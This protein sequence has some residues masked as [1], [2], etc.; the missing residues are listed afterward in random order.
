MHPTCSVA[1]TSNSSSSIQRLKSEWTATPRMS[2]LYALPRSPECSGPAAGSA[3]LTQSPTTTSPPKSAP[4]G[5]HGLD[6]WPAPYIEYRERLGGGR[7]HRHHNRSHPPGHRWHGLSH[8]QS[9]QASRLTRATRLCTEPHYPSGAMAET[10]IGSGSP[11]TKGFATASRGFSG[12]VVR[13]VSVAVSPINRDTKTRAAFPG[14]LG[15][16]DRECA[17][18]E[19]SKWHNSIGQPRRPWRPLQVHA[20][21]E[22]CDVWR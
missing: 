20:H 8:H 9:H 18:V 22:N 4:S 10:A 3:S 19:R 13:S 7:V 5:V 2:N 12:G 15:D 14:V 1:R 11:V 6:A 16:L 17:T 21:S